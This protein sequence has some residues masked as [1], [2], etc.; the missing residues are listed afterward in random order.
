MG[1]VP[2]RIIRPHRGYQPADTPPQQNPPQSVLSSIPYG[3]STCQVADALATFF[4][5]IKV[6][7]IPK[8]ELAS[9]DGAEQW[10]RDH[11]IVISDEGYE[12]GE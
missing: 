9:Y 3:Y 4:S 5:G 10:T 1:F 7:D 11:D 12:V 2:P 6:L 8:A